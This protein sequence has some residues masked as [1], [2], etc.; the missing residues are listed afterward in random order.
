MGGQRTVREEGASSGHADDEHRSVPQQASE[1]AS[2]GTE[3]VE[4]RHA[5][6]SRR[7]QSIIWISKRI[8]VVE[9]I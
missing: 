2:G 9:T 1:E 6:S 7:G 8:K 5:P 3:S 4:Y